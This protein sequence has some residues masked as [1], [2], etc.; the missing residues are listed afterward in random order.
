[1]TAGTTNVSVE[2]R[3]IHPYANVPLDGPREVA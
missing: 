1:M 2:E 3:I